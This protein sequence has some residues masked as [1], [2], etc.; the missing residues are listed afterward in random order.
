MLDEALAQI[1]GVGLGL[2]KQTPA[3]P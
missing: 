2:G 1:E 3:A